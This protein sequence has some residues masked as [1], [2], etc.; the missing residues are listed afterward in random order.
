MNAAPSRRVTPYALPGMLAE[1]AR[2]T[3]V[4]AAIAIAR[5]FGGSNISLPRAPKPGHRLA[6]LVGPEAA[7]IICKRFG[8]ERWDIPSAR[9]F[10]HWHDAHRLRDEGLSVSAIARRLGIGERRV[11]KLL[12]GR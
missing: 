4:D 8:G 5:A 1:I 9:P 2:F 6:L 3:S 7:V 12:E 10:L 11:R